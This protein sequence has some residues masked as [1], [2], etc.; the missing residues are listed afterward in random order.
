MY[1]AYFSQAN[2]DINH[3]SNISIWKDIVERNVD[4]ARVSNSD[5]RERVIETETVF[6]IQI[7]GTA[8][9]LKSYK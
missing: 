4:K 6:T 7:G 3:H 1:Q 2:I 8:P 5:N 9:H